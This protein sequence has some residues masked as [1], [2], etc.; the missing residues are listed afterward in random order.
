MLDKTHA[1]A[2]PGPAGA[3]WSLNVCPFEGE[4]EHRVAGAGYDRHVMCWN[5]S[6]RIQRL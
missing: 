6:S 4:W 5:L 3:V 1:S 2:W